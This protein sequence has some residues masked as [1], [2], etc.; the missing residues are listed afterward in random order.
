[1]GIFQLSQTG[2]AVLTLTIVGIMFILFLRE[3]YPTEVV[4]IAGAAVMLATGVL[5]YDSARLVLANPAPWTIVA[6]FIIMGALVRTGALDAFTALAGRQARTNPAL[7]I[8][9]LMAFVVGSSAIVS[10]TPVVVVMIPVFMQISK[11]M[12]LAPS[13]LLIPLS[14]AA[15]LGG[16]L[17]LIGTST[18]LLVD[19]SARANG[20]AP[21]T[22]FEVT[23]L[24]AILVVWGMIYLRFVAPWLL[25]DR[26]SMANLLSDK[27]KMKFFT[28]AVIPPDSN[29]IGREVSGVQL[30]KREGVRLIDVVRGDQSLRRN[31]AGVS[32]QVGD[33]VVLRT[34]MT[35][36]LSLQSNKELKRVDQVSAVE[37]QTVEVL[38]TPGC[39]M[40]GRSLGS[41]R[42]RR[43]YGVYT[44]AVHRRNQ[45]I[46]Q[47][48]DDLVVRVGD[49]LLLEGAQEDIARLAS[50]MDMVDVSHP[51]SRAFRRGHAPIAIGALIGIVALAAFGVAPILLL[52]VLA[53]AIVLIT[54][55][56]DADEAFEFIDGSLLAL[57]FAML[58]IGAALEASGAVTLIANGI[59]PLISDLPPFFIIWAIYLL[60]S[61][62]TELVS[63]NAVAVVMTPIAI[64]LGSALGIDP[65]ALVVA[66]MVAASAS[67]ATPIGYQTNML[68]YGPGGYK[69]TDFM[70]VGIPLNLS[71]GLLASAVIPFLWP[72]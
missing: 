3:T 8:G 15:I 47:Q 70:R 69:F 13:K 23:P 41:M 26:D 7:A 48:L 10:N 18:N 68:V 54:G 42:L 57:I 34:Q 12:G 58:A 38:I 52:S 65:R 31:L 51:S 25:P 6:M 14:Y 11:T 45:N 4:A 5:P 50:D 28:E 33:R 24:G 35:E 20:L 1:M 55:C 9:L 30:F 56:I 72:L 32:L 43:R 19:G 29:L 61:V 44:L 63:N 21:F 36:L 39:K 59:A 67:F 71:I 49:T 53:V 2:S 64:G 37:T 16:T 60:T 27:R 40:I 46:G 22:I 62:L 66:V 17:T